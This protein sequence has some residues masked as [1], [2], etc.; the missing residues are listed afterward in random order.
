MTKFK[1]IS[2]DKEILFEAD[3]SYKNLKEMFNNGVKINIME[4][5]NY[6]R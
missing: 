1:L 3:I 5:N 4:K 6:V 2:K